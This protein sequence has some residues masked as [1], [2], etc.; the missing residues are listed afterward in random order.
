M[1]MHSIENMIHCRSKD[2]HDHERMCC[3]AVHLNEAITVQEGWTATCNLD[4]AQIPFSYHPV[5]ANNNT[6]CI[7]TNWRAVDGGPVVEKV[8]RDVLT[9]KSGFYTANGTMRVELERL[10]NLSYYGRDADPAVRSLAWRNAFPEGGPLEFS[11]TYEQRVNAFSVAVTRATSD[12]VTPRVITPYAVFAP[13]MN[14]LSSADDAS[15]ITRTTTAWET[16]GVK[17]LKAGTKLQSVAGSLEF[18]GSVNTTGEDT[19]Y[20]R[21]SWG[22]GISRSFET[23]TGHSGNL[24]AKIPVY[25]DPYT[26]LHYSGTGGFHAVLRDGPSR[27]QDFEVHLTDSDGRVLDLDGLDWE[28]SLK[29]TLTPKPPAVPRPMT[30]YARELTDPRLAKIISQAYKQNT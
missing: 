15:G 9:I 17:K 20:F 26:V 14:V 1:S 5:N 3:F 8:Q 29:I 23:R 13:Y 10:L 12:G 24:L 19:I 21:C 16:V 27:L 28:F 30:A 6:L 22:T 18:D 4:N 2:R 11:V 25:G 7:E